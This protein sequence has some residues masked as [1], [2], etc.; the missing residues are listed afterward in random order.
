MDLFHRALAAET[1][2]IPI[3]FTEWRETV[4]RTSLTFLTDPDTWLEVW[5]DLETHRIPDAITLARVSINE[6]HALATA[7]TFGELIMSLWQAVRIE[8]AQAIEHWMPPLTFRINPTTLS[9]ALRAPSVE[10]SAMGAEYDM[11][12][13]ALGLPMDFDSLGLWPA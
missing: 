5:N 4:S 1:A 10:G 13:H 3:R 7:S 12:K 8:N 9:E 2:A 11:S 6:I